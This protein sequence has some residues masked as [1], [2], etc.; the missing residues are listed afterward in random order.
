[1]GLVGP[2]DFGLYCCA[3]V[4]FGL[5]CVV[6]PWCS[7]FIVRWFSSGMVVL[8]WYGGSMVVRLF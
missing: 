1:M 5:C 6:V 7:S 2:Y 3:V 8:R 4:S